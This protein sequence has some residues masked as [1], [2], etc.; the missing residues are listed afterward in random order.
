MI[1]K[2]NLITKDLDYYINLIKQQQ[3]LRRLTSI[4]KE[5][6]LWVKCYQIASDAIENYL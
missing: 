4:L 1:E 3:G 5:V 6:L 2:K